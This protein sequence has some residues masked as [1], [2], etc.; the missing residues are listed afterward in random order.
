MQIKNIS[1]IYYI[2]SLYAV[3]LSIIA[4]FNF[5]YWNDGAHYF[6][7]FLNNQT[8]F[9]DKFGIRYI[10]LLPQ[11]IPVWLMQNNFELSWV[12]YSYKWLLFAFPQIVIMA[13]ILRSYYRGES[14]TAHLGYVLL[15]IFLPFGVALS[16][17]QTTYTIVGSYMIFSLLT[18]KKNNYLD[19]FLFFLGHILQLMGYEL[20]IVVLYSVIFLSILKFKSLY[21]FFLFESTFTLFYSA[22]LIS[23]QAEFTRYIKIIEDYIAY[24]KIAYVSLFLTIF[25]Y[26]T[27]QMRK[28]TKIWQWSSF[29]IGAVLLYLI[30]GHYLFWLIINY[31][32]SLFFLFAA[33][34]S[35]L[36]LQNDV[37]FQKPIPPI[38]LVSLFFIKVAYTY[39]NAALDLKSKLVPGKCLPLR[40]KELASPLLT[41]WSLFFTSVL[42]QESQEINSLIVGSPFTSNGKCQLFEGNRFITGNL[43]F[44]SSYNFNYFK[45]SSQLRTDLIPPRIISKPRTKI[46]ELHWNEHTEFEFVSPS[47]CLEVQLADDATKKHHFS[48]KTI[49]SGPL[50]LILSDQVSRLQSESKPLIVQ[51]K[52]HQVADESPY[53]SFRIRE[54]L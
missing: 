44:L 13:L 38:L 3:F 28:N 7:N 45:L 43:D 8:Y 24:D 36:F 37:R 34:A 53:V 18:N 47:G 40:P 23:N 51:L 30:E 50:P 31:R 12:L 26:L 42:I 49:D 15:F 5:H 46:L 17:A 52:K 1:R 27:F 4:S 20:G 48:W 9:N 25:S 29:T 6:F 33:Y 10:D 54:C 22:Y 16:I 2:F 14:K 21:R 41:E 35:L 19:Y 32:W 11:I 39:Q